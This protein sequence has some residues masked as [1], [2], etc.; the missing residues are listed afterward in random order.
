MEIINY[1]G[2]LGVKQE[3]DWQVI[4][5]TIDSKVRELRPLLNNPNKEIWQE[6]EKRLKLYLEA[7]QVLLDPAKR[8][9]YDLSIGKPEKSRLQ[10][11][12]N[13]EETI[14]MKPPLQK[15]EVV[16]TAKC[17]TKQKVFHIVFSQDSHEKWIFNR[18]YLSITSGEYKGII[19]DNKIEI[20]NFDFRNYTCPLCGN[21]NVAKCGQCNCLSCQDHNITEFHCPWCGIAGEIS[22]TFDKLTA[23]KNK[24]GTSE[25]KRNLSSLESKPRKERELNIE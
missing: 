12:L 2:I 24:T 6:A 13:L 25:T 1:Y 22:G 23:T 4:K 8:T 16:V 18:T 11:I 19:E 7:R 10:N 5:E 21:N 14:Q 17:Q 15:K 20:S 3:S 9:A